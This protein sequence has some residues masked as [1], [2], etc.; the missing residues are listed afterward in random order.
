M[1]MSERARQVLGCIEDGLTG[2][3]P[4]LA[5]MRGIFSRLTSGEEMST[6]EKIQVRRRAVH[7][8]RRARPRAT[9]PTKIPAQPAQPKGPRTASH[10]RSARVF[11]Y[12]SLR[13]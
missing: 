9:I 13:K 8:P 4:A 10:G 5:S 6:R 11:R 7:S 2:S 1:G 12:G 3:D